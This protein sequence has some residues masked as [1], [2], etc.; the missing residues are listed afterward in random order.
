MVSKGATNLI[1]PTRSAVLS[2][3]AVD[4]MKELQGQGITVTTVECDVASR[5]MLARALDD[6]RQTLPPIRGCINAAMVLNVSDH[7]YSLSWHL[8]MA[9]LLGRGV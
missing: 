1:V 9:N 8:L 2:A 6:W 5:D 7:P 3:V 4:I